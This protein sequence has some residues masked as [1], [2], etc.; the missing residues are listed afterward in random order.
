[1]IKSPIATIV[2]SPLF[3]G[4]SQGEIEEL[5]YYCEVMIFDNGFSFFSQGDASEDI[6]VVVDG[7]VRLTVKDT[8][9]HEQ[10]IG[11][12]E[13]GDIIGEM[14]VF[15]NEPRSTSA[16]ALGETVLL[17]VPGDGFQ[18]M[19]KAGHPAIHK[20]LQWSLKKAGERL[21]QL[22]HKLGLLF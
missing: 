20:M 9:D 3:S 15:E 17:K 1:V 8:A 14:G 18:A 12:V 22:D 16:Y 10:D 2:R 6:Y 4:L 11:I 13:S 5:A 7:R 19:M 21:R